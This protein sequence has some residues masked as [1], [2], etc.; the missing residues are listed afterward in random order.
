VTQCSWAH[1]IYNILHKLPGVDG[2][3]VYQK[4]SHNMLKSI[5]VCLLVT[6]GGE[7]KLRVS[8]QLKVSGGANQ[9]TC[10]DLLCTKPWKFLIQ[11]QECWGNSVHFIHKF[12]IMP[13]LICN[14][15]NKT[16]HVATRGWWAMFFV[17]G[18]CG[19]QRPVL[20]AVVNTWHDY[21]FSSGT[22]DSGVTFLWSHQNGSYLRI[23]ANVPLICLV[24]HESK[25]FFHVFTCFLFA[26][27][28]G[29]RD[30]R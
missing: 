25:N 15:G 26:D 6:N 22:I 27:S 5:P 1:K 18:I 13:S 24:V 21:T 30:W 23:T 3:Y 28:T 2:F 16:L 10:F 7:T 12:F 29:N 17:P 19:L 11:E 9:Y 4:T 20:L 14:D 8:E